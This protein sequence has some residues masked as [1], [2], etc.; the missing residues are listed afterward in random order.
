MEFMWI[1]VPFQSNLI[2]WLCSYYDQLFAC[3]KIYK[4]PYQWFINYNNIYNTLILYALAELF[5]F[6]KHFCN[7]F[8][9]I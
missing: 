7:S 4:Y 3:L 8:F 2:V 5:F 1:D 9:E 6:K